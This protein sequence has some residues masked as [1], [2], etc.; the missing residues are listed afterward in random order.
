MPAGLTFE[1]LVDVVGSIVSQ[2]HCVPV[3]RTDQLN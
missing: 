1:V 3:S 2:V